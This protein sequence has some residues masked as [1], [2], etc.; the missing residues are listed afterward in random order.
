MTLSCSICHQ[1]FDTPGAL[2]F[3]PPSAESLVRKY[4][5]CTDCF[6]FAI[7]PLFSGPEEEKG[8]G[9]MLPPK[10]PVPAGATTQPA[11]TEQAL[12]QP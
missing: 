8:E 7:I 12:P 3:S 5:V 11:G 9:A 10:D 4:H 2:V 6:Y 1:D